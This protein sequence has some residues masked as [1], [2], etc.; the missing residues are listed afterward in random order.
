V[1]A[2]SLLLIDVDG[3]R[4]DVF[5]IALQNEQL[6]GFSGLLGGGNL[7][8]GLL[9]PA[10]STAPSITF[11]SQASLFTGAHPAQHG[12]PGNQF[13]DRFGR[14]NQGSPRHY[15][16]DVGDTLAVEDA[17]LVFSDGLA[18]RCLETPTIYEK[19]GSSGWHSVVAGHMYAAGADTWL[20]PSLLS[21]ARFTAG[22]N[23]FGMSPADFDRQTLDNLLESIHRDGLPD[24]ITLYFLGLDHESHTHG[25]QTQSEYLINV[26]D[27][28]VSQLWQTL[29]EMQRTADKNAPVCAIFSDHGH[30]L[31]PNDDRHSLRLA[32]PFERELGRFFD[33]L[34][35]DVLDVPGESLN[36]DAVVASNG[37]LAHVY[38]RNRKSRQ[39]V[40]PPD[41]DLDILPVGLALWQAHASGRYTPDLQNA[42]AGVLLRDVE[43]QGWNAPYQALSPQ[44]A[45]SSLEEWFADQPAQQYAD[46]VNRLNNLVGPMCGDILLFSNYAGGYYFAA[47]MLGMHG[48]L[49]P[50]DSRATM[51]FGCPGF[52]ETEWS[53]ARAALQQAIQARCQAENGRHPS[54]T[55]LLTG[56]MTLI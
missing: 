10:L 55:D 28:L 36:C 4:P 14:H 50:E 45:R 23:L 22:R 7:E 34:G 26:I 9:Q 1:T 53:A 35:L 30:L 8:R 12:I 48:G 44:G 16:F 39:W 29:L 52:S 33:A 40:E 11:T 47:P 37:G 46:P 51:A 49:H 32:F 5:S 21:L 6:P 2:S 42:L 13:F 41:F 18:S 25:P 38:L 20:K 3:L 56:L 43:H 19:L 24:L 31:V 54:T 27:P 17:L 15:A